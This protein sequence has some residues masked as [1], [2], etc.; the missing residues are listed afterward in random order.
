MTGALLF[1]EVDRPARERGRVLG[2]VHAGHLVGEMSRTAET[3]RIAH[4]SREI[5]LTDAGR[6][7]GGF[8][9][10]IDLG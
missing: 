10:R 2:H 5:R 4:W 3:G 1:A 7:V 8:H 6:G 9:E